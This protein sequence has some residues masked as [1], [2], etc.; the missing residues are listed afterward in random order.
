MDT[1]GVNVS[2]Y[3]GNVWSCWRCR[4]RWSWGRCSSHRYP[5][6]WSCS[7]W[8]L[9]P[10]PGG[11]RLEGTA[12]SCLGGRERERKR[13]NNNGMESVIIHHHSQLWRV[14]WNLFTTYMLKKYGL[15]GWKWLKIGI[16]V[17]QRPN[18]S[19]LTRQMLVRLS[20][21]IVLFCCVSIADHTASIYLNT[22]Y[23]IM[24]L[25]MS[26][27]PVWD[28]LQVYLLVPAVVSLRLSSWFPWKTTFI[29]NRHIAFVFPFYNI[30][31]QC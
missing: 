2:S 6:F 19:H 27:S 20:L 29:A 10:S 25:L 21:H 5:G 31:Q 30:P 9:R 18:H 26:H 24:Y 12:S 16:M 7:V 28:K 17:L 23:W 1:T 14:F 15:K 11:P 3:C 8:P 13:E 22:V 4:W